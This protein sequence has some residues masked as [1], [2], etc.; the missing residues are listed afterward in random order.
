MGEQV[1]TKKGK[2]KW[3]KYDDWVCLR[4]HNHNYSFRVQCTSSIM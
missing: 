3:S 4:C 2:A 1:L